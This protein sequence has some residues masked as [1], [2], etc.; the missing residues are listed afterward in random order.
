MNFN[1][2]IAL[3]KETNKENPDVELLMR[4]EGSSFFKE[5]GAFNDPVKNK[6]VKDL[7]GNDYLTVLNTGLYNSHYTT[8]ETIRTVMEWLI[9]QLPSNP[10]ILDVGC[11]ATMGW[12][13]HSPPF[14]CQYTGVE[15]CPFATRVAKAIARGKGLKVNIWNVDFC[16]WKYPIKFDAWIGNIP[17]VSATSKEINGKKYP[18]HYKIFDQGVD[19]VKS[20]GLI[21]VITTIYTLDSYGD[22][23]I[24][25]RTKLAQKVDL[26]K[27]IRL[28]PN[29]H[30]GKTDV[31]SDLL[32]FRR[33]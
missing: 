2:A 19:M 8:P 18:L 10:T 31:T 9:P 7:L 20:N 11:G 22:K 5:L 3:I 28:P 15:I 27:A 30:V 17:F 4:Y 1:D 13:T 23:A 26:I 14:P 21:C 29:A 32:I 16:E 6:I 33:K 12:L 25:F 24:A